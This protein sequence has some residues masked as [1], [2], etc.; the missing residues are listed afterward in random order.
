MSEAA[1]QYKKQQGRLI[2]AADGR[3]VSWK[4]DAGNATVDVDIAAITSTL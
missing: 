1:A 4:A 3:A 2:V